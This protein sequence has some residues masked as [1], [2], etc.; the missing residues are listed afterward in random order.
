MPCG[1]AILPRVTEP[2]VGKRRLVRWPLIAGCVLLI[3][4]TAVYFNWWD[5]Y[6]ETGLGQWA[7]AEIAERS[8][9]VYSLQLG[10]LD[11]RPVAGSMSFDSAIIVTDTVLDRAQGAPLPVLSVRAVG[12]RISRVNVL[13]LMVGNRFSARAM[14]C[15]SVLTAIDLVAPRSGVAASLPS[16]SGRARFGGFG[17]A[18]SDASAAWNREVSDCESRV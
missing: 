8:G 12:C 18:H 11:F 15:E 9:G 16:P 7:V 6:V 2:R 14:G 1:P 5:R 17:S 3:G 10:D 4:G 13:S